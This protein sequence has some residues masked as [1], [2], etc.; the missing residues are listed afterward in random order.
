MKSIL[1]SNV[2]CYYFITRLESL[3]WAMSYALRAT[4]L[5]N[6]KHVFLSFLWIFQVVSSVFHWIDLEFINVHRHFDSRFELYD[7]ALCMQWNYTHKYLKSQK[8]K[9]RM[10]IFQ[11]K[12]KKIIIYYI[13]ITY[14]KSLSRNSINAILIIH[15]FWHLLFSLSISRSISILRHG[16]NERMQIIK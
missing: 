3:A 2:K 6:I 13:L 4:E 5:L 14:W 1:E 8:E 16:A 10:N 7:C 9:K 15:L 12:K 11:I